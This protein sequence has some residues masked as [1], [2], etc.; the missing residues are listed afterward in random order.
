MGDCKAAIR[1]LRAASRNERKKERKVSAENPDL[2]S[3]LRSDHN[4]VLR[5][6]AYT[7][8]T[9]V[10]GLRRSQRKIYRSSREA[11]QLPPLFRQLSDLHR[12]PCNEPPKYTEELERMRQSLSNERTD[13]SFPN[14]SPSAVDLRKVLPRFTAETARRLSSRPVYPETARSRRCFSTYSAVR[15]CQEASKREPGYEELFR[16][17]NSMTNFTQ[18]ATVW[19]LDIPLW[20]LELIYR[21]LRDNEIKQGIHA[22]L[23][24]NLRDLVR[25]LE[26][27]GNPV[28]ISTNTTIDSTLQSERYFRR[29]KLLTPQTSITL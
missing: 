23:A 5:A 20:E 28:F 9:T 17:C 8:V 14:N 21:Y 2:V 13:E 19:E 11:D 25:Q 15:F 29:M 1:A 27:A 26:A 7:G 16:E 6:W 18:L 3:E 22:S 10:P 12:H 24:D 4:S